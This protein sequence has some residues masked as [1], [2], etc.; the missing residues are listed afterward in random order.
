MVGHSK[1]VRLFQLINPEESHTTT[2]VLEKKSVT[3]KGH[4]DVIVHLVCC[5]GR[6]Y[7]AG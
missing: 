4:S 2:E 7:S 5:E 6:F 3:C 1:K